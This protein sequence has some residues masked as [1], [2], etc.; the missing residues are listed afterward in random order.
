MTGMHKL[1]SSCF[2]G[3]APPFSGQAFLGRQRA[4]NS[5][6]QRAIQS[7]V[8]RSGKSKAM[9]GQGGGAQTLGSPSLAYSDR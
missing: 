6:D 1:A 9:A 3:L 7:R 2:I 4:L 5:P 8:L